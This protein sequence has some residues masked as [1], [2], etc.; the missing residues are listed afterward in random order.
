MKR[1]MKYL[2][3]TILLF[4]SFV[5]R[6]QLVYPVAGTYKGKSA[7]GMAISRD[8]AFLFND[9]GLC[10]SFNLKNGQVISDFY[11]GSASSNNHVNSASFGC[12]HVNGNIYPVIYVSECRSPYR[13][14]VENITDSTSQI[15]QTLIIKREGTDSIA[16][17]W[18]VD[19]KR[20]RIYGINNLEIV[21][22]MTGNRRYNITAYRLPKIC[23]G[24]VALTDKDV[25]DS[26][27]VFFPNVL[28]G[29]SI[30][31]N[32]LYM[33]VGFQKELENR[34]DAKRA[35]IVINLK[36]HKIEKTIDLTNITDKEPED[37]DFYQGRA[38][39][40]TGQEGGLYEVSL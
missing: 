8:R 13:C 35:V 29:A 38:L 3:L 31:K 33:P 22:Q 7:Q 25:M 28:Q 21:D 5:C 30:Y 2:H 16:K 23:E 34:L 40:Y 39:L 1:M 4:I 27:D 14:F 37:M 19:F 9:G 26:F 18:V 15:V 32:R 10:R 36:K 12:E 17:D 24:N 6:A 11:I 20:K